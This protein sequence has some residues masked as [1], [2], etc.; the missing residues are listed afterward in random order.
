[1]LLHRFANG[2]IQPY[3]GQFLRLFIRVN[4]LDS[5]KPLPPP[6]LTLVFVGEAPLSDGVAGGEA[7]PG[8]GVVSGDGHGQDPSVGGHAARRRLTAVATNVGTHWGWGR[9]KRLI[10]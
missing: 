3:A 1:M 5:V 4:D 7:L 6:P 8:D 9:E 2:Q 10:C